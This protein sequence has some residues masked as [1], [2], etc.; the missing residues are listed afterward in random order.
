MK[1]R[2]LITAIILCGFSQAALAYTYAQNCTANPTYKNFTCYSDTHMGA[3]YWFIDG[4]AV[5]SDWI[6]NS[7]CTTSTIVANSGNKT[8]ANSGCT[9]K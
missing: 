3:K 2:T 5:P 9:F 4:T 7:V 8:L 6:K 1:I